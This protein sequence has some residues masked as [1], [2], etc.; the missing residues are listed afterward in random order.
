MNLGNRIKNTMNKFNKI[1]KQIFYFQEEIIII[2]IKIKMLK[3]K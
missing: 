3:N 2:K 1:I